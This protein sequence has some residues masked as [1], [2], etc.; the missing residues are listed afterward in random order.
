MQRC[1]VVTF[2]EVLRS[3]LPQICIALEDVLLKLHMKLAPGWELIRGNFDPIQELGQIRE[4]ALFC[5]T[6][7]CAN[8]AWGVGTRLKWYVHVDGRGP[9][10]V[11][12]TCIL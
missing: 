7:A 6:T 5:E 8:L 9:T 11:I 12:H 4:W 10:S 3:F 2:G 1:L